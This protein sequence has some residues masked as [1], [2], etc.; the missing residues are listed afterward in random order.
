MPVGALAE[1]PAE[2]LPIT[3]TM[4]DDNGDEVGFGSSSFA[5][6]DRQGDP[7]EFED[8]TFHF[9]KYTDRDLDVNTAGE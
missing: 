9:V 4:D 8:C 2:V 7:V 1:L 3:A 6:S 5:C